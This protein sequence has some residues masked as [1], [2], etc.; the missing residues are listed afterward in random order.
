MIQIK[1]TKYT[2]EEYVKT[3]GYVTGEDV[4]RAVLTKDGLLNSY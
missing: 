4:S 1:F 2:N 3:V